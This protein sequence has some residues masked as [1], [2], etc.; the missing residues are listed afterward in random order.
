MAKKAENVYKKPRVT[1]KRDFKKNW[2]IYLMGAPMMIYLIIFKFIPMFGIIMAFEDYKPTLGYF[3]SKWVGMQNFIDLFTGPEFLQALRN[4]FF[5]G[6]LNFLIGFT[7]PIGFALVLSMLRNKKFKRVTQTISYMPNFVSS[8]VVCSLVTVFLS[9]TGP[10]TMLL[11]ALG[12]PQQNWLANDQI[13]VFWIINT[14]MNVW[15]GLGWGTIVYVAA[16]SNVSGELHEAAAIDGANR[17]QRTVK[18]TLP[19]I[20]PMVI[21]MMTL[22]V[23]IMF[24]AGFD[25]VLLLYMPSTYSVADCLQTYTYRTAFTTGANYGLS[26]ASGLFQA[27]VATALLFGSNALNRKASGMAL[28]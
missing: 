27:V 24:L 26:T 15:I 7:L 18:I 19:C 1:W 8:V 10:L 6:L 20:K 5:M 23:G 14:F 9:R 3:K 17:F 22:N 28:F 12:L 13:P 16:I 21:M 25:K 2:L 11:T 4:T